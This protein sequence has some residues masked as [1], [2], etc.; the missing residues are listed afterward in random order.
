MSTAIKDTFDELFKHKATLRSID[1]DRRAP[2]ARDEVGLVLQRPDGH[3][4]RL[5]FTDCRELVAQ[6][7]FGN[8]G[9]E[10][11]L[12]AEC[13]EDSPQLDGIRRAWAK[14][15]I[16]FS[17]LRS[18]E[19][20]TASAGSRVSMVA[21]GFEL[22]APTSDPAH[23]RDRAT[24]DTI[25]VTASTIKEQFLDFP[26]HDANLRL[27]EIDRT[28]PGRR[29]E[30]ALV[31]EWPD[32]RRSRLVFTCCYL[33]DAKL[34][35]GV[36]AGGEWIYSA[37]CSTDSVEVARVRERRHHHTDIPD[38]HCF[39]IDTS[40]TGSTIRIVARGFEVHPPPDDSWFPPREP[41]DDEP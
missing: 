39:E 25:S 29:D 20:A 13:R 2:G 32:G 19:I 21:P 26:W 27:I 16:D 11:I 33:F 1:I 17:N 6:L 41:E 24:G 15:S 37:A 31:I 28:D 14:F 30:V 35:F 18:F 10:T 36:D 38:L 7:N 22:G 9:P 3:R 8:S 23:E 40:S 12:S 4:S 5:V 34:N